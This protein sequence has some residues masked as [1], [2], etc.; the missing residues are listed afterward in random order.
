L[1]RATDGF[2][3][4]GFVCG[5]NDILPQNHQYRVGLFLCSGK[6]YNICHK[7]YHKNATRMVTDVNRDS[8]E[9]LNLIS[10]I[11]NLLAKPLFH[12]S[13][14][15]KGV[16]HSIDILPVTCLAWDGAVQPFLK[17]SHEI[18]EDSPPPAQFT[19]MKPVW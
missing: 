3:K 13:P 8:N 19:P 16:T 9:L 2:E 6:P 1:S 18:W 10:G 12:K 5:T 14:G 11:Q 7:N 4:Y 17:Y 15:L